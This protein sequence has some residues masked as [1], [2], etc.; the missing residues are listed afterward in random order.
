MKFRALLLATSLLAVSPALAAIDPPAASKDD[1]R[2]RTVVYDPNNP[3]Q[4][5]TAPGASLRLEFGADEEIVQVVT[6]DQDILSPDPNAPQLP[7]AKVSSGL[8]D[9]QGGDASKLPPSCGPDLCRSVWGNIVYIKPIR[10]L[11][12]Q[13]L[14]IQT[15]R[16]HPN[17]KAEMVAYTFELST[18][19]Y[20]TGSKAPSVWGVRFVYPERVR[21]AQAAAWQ[22]K[23][24]QS[25]K[26]AADR[27]SMAQPASFAPGP[28][29]NFQYGYRGT[30][31][32]RPDEAWDDGRSTFLRFNGNRR[33]PNIYS[34]LPGGKETLSATS[35][36]PDPTGNTLKIA[37][38]GSKWFLRD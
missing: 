30:E 15:R 26:E 17:G 10:P 25:E 9:S 18:K 28:S 3:V 16:D 23:K 22:W 1:S 32:L 19:T 7:V 12:P 21:A 37:G 27:A 36:E 29:A 5:Y 8:P 11:N 35:T 14:F 2:I 38:T 31:S 6:S 34:Q 13:P 4:I 24:H 20:D 33:V